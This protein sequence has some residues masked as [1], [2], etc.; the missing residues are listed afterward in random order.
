MAGMCCCI[1][2]ETSQIG[3]HL[4]RRWYSIH[5]PFLELFTEH[6]TCLHKIV[7]RA[8]AGLCVLALNDCNFP[9]THQLALPVDTC[10]LLQGLPGVHSCPHAR[11]DKQMDAGDPGLAVPGCRG[12]QQ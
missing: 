3:G 12:S 5:K 7:G 11:P 8:S 6:I 10:H 1:S 2:S 4:C 9:P